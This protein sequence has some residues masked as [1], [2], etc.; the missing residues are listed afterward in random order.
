MLRRLA[1][2]AFAAGGLG[3]AVFWFVTRPVGLDGAVIAQAP[4]GDAA[5]GEAVFW[6]A[7]CASC[8]AAPGA[9]GE[10]RLRLGGGLKLGS[11]FGS[12]VAPNI[13]PDREDGIGAWDFASFANAMQRGVSPGG[14][15]YYPAFPYSSYARMTIGDVADLFAFMQTLPAVAGRQPGHDLPFPFSIR[16]LLGGWKFLFFRPGPAVALDGAGD[17]VRRGQYLVEGP[18]HCGECHT[19]RNLLGGPR[20]DAWLSGAANPEGKGVIPN[21]TGGKGGIAA[22]SESEIASFLAD[23][24]TPDFD[25]A[26]G[27]MAQ[28]VLNWSHVGD[29]D[30]AAVAAYLK[31]V[32]PLPDGATAR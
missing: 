1:L 19:P 16:R 17:A 29:A 32:P 2:A 26:G 8:H 22:W 15:H 31:A 7:G 10:D 5:R 24:F 11:P 30:R 20:R 3:L 12:F 25:S 9:T 4:A 23:G 13:S 28:V 14:E 21:I 6:Q 27:T 18:G